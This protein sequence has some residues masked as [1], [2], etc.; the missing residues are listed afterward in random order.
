MGGNDAGKDKAARESDTLA[1]KL[2]QNGKILKMLTLEHFNEKALQAN[3]KISS[4]LTRLFLFLKTVLIIDF[5][6]LFPLFRCLNFF[7][8][9]YRWTWNLPSAPVSYH[10]DMKDANGKTALHYAADNGNFSIIE[11]L[12]KYGANIDAIDDHNQSPLLI[13][14]KMHKCR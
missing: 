4:F 5:F 12:L 8:L 1:R 2:M 6:Q 7:L 13:G 10:A 9:A 11:T 14:S 3:L